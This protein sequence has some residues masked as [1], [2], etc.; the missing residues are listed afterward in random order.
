MQFH[1]TLEIIVI[2]CEKSLKG[3]L[4]I[5]VVGTLFYS[6]IIERKKSVG[7]ATVEKHTKTLNSDAVFHGM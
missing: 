2:G 1:D 7:H 4:Y 6:I 5:F 3:L